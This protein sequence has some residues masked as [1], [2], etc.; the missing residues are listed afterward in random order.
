M[1]R[2]KPMMSNGHRSCLHRVFISF[3]VFVLPFLMAFSLLEAKEEKTQMQYQ[4]MKDGLKILERT[5]GTGEEAKP[6][7]RVTVHYVGTL[8]KNGQ[9]FDSSRDRGQPFTFVLGSGQV[10]QGWDRGVAGMKVGGLRQL[11]IPSNLAYGDS[12]YG[13]IPGKSTLV[14]EVELLAV[15]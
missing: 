10:I 7:R 3:C 11:V 6:G 13:P 9:K 12:G 14:F 2:E 1:M 8:E 5:Q 15:S 4:Q